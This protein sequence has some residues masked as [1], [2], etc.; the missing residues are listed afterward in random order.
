M[1]LVG[2]VKTRGPL[3]PND[4]QAGTDLPTA[5]QVALREWWKLARARPAFRGGGE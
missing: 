4:L 2:V 3:L 5:M 1:S